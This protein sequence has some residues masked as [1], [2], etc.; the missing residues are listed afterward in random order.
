MPKV[1]SQDMLAFLDDLHDWI[2][3]GRTAKDFAELKGISNSTVSYRM[4][5]HGLDDKRAEG[6]VDVRDGT[7]YPELKRRGE[8]ETVSDPEPAVV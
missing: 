6:L 2:S 5:S 3:Q 7:P 4:R 8:F 1:V